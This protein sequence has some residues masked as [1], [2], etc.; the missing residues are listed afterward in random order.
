MFTGRI[1]LDSHAW[2][3]D[4][5]VFDTV[6]L[7]GTSFVELA[8]RAGTQVG[9]ETVEEIT[10]EAPLIVPER[11][12][13][14][15]QLA[16]A[17]P[18]EDGRRPIAIHS[19][20]ASSDPEDVE[21][22]WTRNAS[23][24]L[25]PGETGANAALAELGASA[26]PP[27]GAE[28]IE[29]DFLYDRLAEVGFGY[30]PA[31]QGLRAAWRRGEEL[32]CEV[33]LDE[34]H[35]GEA[36]AFGIHPAL[37]DAALHGGFFGA[38]DAAVRLPFAW[39]GVRLGALGATSLRVRVAS[40]G[41]G[42][43]SLAAVDQSGAPVV[44]VDSLL[45]R[46]VEP[47]QL[48][49][50]RRQHDSLF[51][52]EWTQL[53]APSSN[54]SPP[55]VALVGPAGAELEAALAA[56]CYED[57]GAIEKAI[58]S[59]AA[60]PELVVFDAAAASAAEGELAAAAHEHTA[61]ALALLQDWIATEPLAESRLVFLTH[62]A[63]AV[64]EGE[65]PELAAA[66]L[67]GL[68]HSAHSE[69]PDSFAA[70]DFDGSEASARTLQSA[71]ALCA[72]E[73]QLAL[74]EGEVLVPRLARMKVEAEPEGP[75]HIRTDGSGTLEGLTLTVSSSA[76]APLGADEIRV[77]VRAAGLNFRDA[78]IALGIYPGEAPIGSEGAGVILEVGSEVTDLAVGDR[79]MGLMPDAFGT[80][81]V[82]NCR[83]V[84]R[85]PECWSFAEGAS[86]PVAFL[87][88]YYALVD[89]ADL[90]AGERLLVHAAAG[91]VGMA[92]TQLAHHLGAEV[93]ATASP[94]KWE[95]VRGLGVDGD[96]IA[97][98]RTLDFRN[99]FKSTTAEEGVDVVLNALAGDFVDASLDLLPRGGRFIEMGKTDVRDSDEVAES[100]SGVRY[101]AFDLIEAGLERVSE[102][103]VELVE[104]F[105]QGALTLAP[106]K[107]WDVREAVSALRYLSQGRNV[108]KIVLTVPR[109]LDP[110]ATVLIS[111]GTGGLGAL[112]AR[113]LVSA[114][115]ARRLLLVSRRGVEAEGAAELGA[116]LVE[117]GAEVEIAACDVADRDQLA[118]L[119]ES[120]PAERRL[121]AVV[122]AAGVIED[123]TL[124]SLSPERLD[125]VM[126][127]KLDAALNLHELTRGLELSQFVLF[128]SAAATFGSP[129]QANYAAANA[130]LDALAAHRQ[131]GGLPGTSLAWGLWEQASGMTAKLSETDRTRM[132]RMGI[133]PLTSERGLALFDA[134]RALAE[135]LLV[136]APLD[137][138][139]LRAVAR[140]GMLPALLR[141]LVR[142][143]ARRAAAGSL[144]ERLAGVPE[145]EREAVVL[146]LVRSH[147]AAALGH[148]GA[149]AIEAERSF[150]DLGF[151]SLSAVELR[152]RLITATGLRLPATLVFDYPTP[153]AVAGY[154]RDSASGNVES[155][156]DEKFNSIETMVTA[157]AN[158]NDRSRLEPRLRALTE[159]L[160][161][162]LADGSPGGSDGNGAPQLDLDS[163]SDDEL[164]ELIDHEFGRPEIV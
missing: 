45:S 42:A 34:G 59:G 53:A 11:G 108:G 156:L 43:L 144:A 127:P 14:Q 134:G 24:F 97:S 96:R 49:G 113:H 161:K 91:G 143:P 99:A 100:H 133:V 83:M 114:H 141:G 6:L 72:E 148:A 149:E 55:T 22:E 38:E 48:A 74:R 62:G 44:S 66:P 154:L 32:F 70:I 117:L 67:W 88:A 87:T 25:A 75:W 102:M 17:E 112:V 138:A 145:S 76:E 160:H 151:D 7:S 23:G 162:L 92:A 129:G 56:E 139:A 98:S 10:L 3:A 105:E 118:A 77:G 122:H 158:G 64:L 1:S 35:A 60:V 69:R 157:L 126:A 85:M 68:L 19:R 5:A 142:T 30:G 61:A 128:S 107:S 121:G 109:P 124:E 153:A 9:C 80:V 159:R 130:F 132:R 12:A 54:G 147:A 39:Q 27:Q 31:F 41:E 20:P 150:K 47:A 57:L 163:T 95:T 93:F 50:A 40:A 146:D 116:E 115:G 135:P 120:I 136:A 15:L 73:P 63:V 13:V 33:T 104:L 84:V 86:V 94:R 137:T 152:N 21:L 58:E 90:Q 81:C 71:F 123:G 111:G 26:W 51:R 101:R 18:D 131:A 103:L 4:H 2:L 164:L 37:F 119:L 78:L 52:I 36:G 110:E 106:I 89:L 125:R 82:T 155:A 8:L 28:P 79:V 65:S 46:P 16:V 140:A 29:V